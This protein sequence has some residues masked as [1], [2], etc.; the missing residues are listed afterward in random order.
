MFFPSC[1]ALAA[2][3]GALLRE[4]RTERADESLELALEGKCR[5]A[6]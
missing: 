3:A 6:I 2:N 1:I 4:W 5:R